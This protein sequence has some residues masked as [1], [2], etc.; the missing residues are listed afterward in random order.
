MINQK[1]FP[2][3]YISRIVIYGEVLL[4]IFRASHKRGKVALEGDSLAFGPFGFR[5][6]QALR[7]TSKQAMIKSSLVIY[8]RI[9]VT[10]RPPGVVAELGL[11][12]LTERRLS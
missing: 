2:V 5:S 4:A 9:T 3:L 1:H 8:A 6:G 11:G 10:R 12:P 7:M